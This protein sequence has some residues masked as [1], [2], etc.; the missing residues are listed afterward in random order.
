MKRTTI[1]P[2]AQKGREDAVSR[3]AGRE[4][5]REWDGATRHQIPNVK[6]ERSVAVL[7]S[8]VICT[9]LQIPFSAARAPDESM[10]SESMG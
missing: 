4:N 9:R 8:F 1:H 2:S 7:M 3:G 6:F 5:L 10:L